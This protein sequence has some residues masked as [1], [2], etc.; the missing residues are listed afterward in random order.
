M[1]ALDTVS[2]DY[3]HAV[4]SA[5]LSALGEE[6]VGAYLYG[7]AASSSYLHG[8]SDIDMLAVVREPLGPDRV[9]RLLDS[10]RAATRPSAVKG[11]DLWVVPLRSA[12]EPCPEPAFECWLLTAI[13]RELI[14]G[15]DHPG[16]ARLVLLYAM[17]R[18]H[19]VALA[20]PP[21]R[22]VFGP[23][24]RSWLVDAMRVDLAMAGAAG[25]SAR[26]QI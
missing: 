3:T 5:L 19:G 6:L 24:S 2:L 26:N 25:S 4:R 10:V 1:A 21:P 9:R 17:C 7:S 20:G 22:R 13:D 8:Q 12:R 15:D 23:I 18:D 14:G 16:D 11:L